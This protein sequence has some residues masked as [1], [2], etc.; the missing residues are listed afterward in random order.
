MLENLS[1]SNLAL[2][3]KSELDFSG[4]FN[5]VTGESGAGKSILM[6][7]AAILFGGKADHAAI[8]TGCAFAEVSG[9]VSVE[10]RLQ[11]KIKALL[12]EVEIPAEF[13]LLIRRRITASGVRN[14]VNDTGVG[15]KFLSLL[16]AMLIDFHAATDQLDLTIPA[17][18]LEMLDRFAGL[19]KERENCRILVGKLQELARERAD[20]EKNNVSGDEADTLREMVA[21][22]EKVNPEAGEE[23]RLAG[24]YKMIA[25]AKEVLSLC[26]RVRNALNEA[27]D[28]IVD[29]LG[30]V[31]RDLSEL[32]RLEG[33]GEETEKLLASCDELQENLNDLARKVGHLA[34][35]TDLDGEALQA[36]EARLEEL[37]A[38]KRRYKVS[39]EEELLEMT[40]SA[41]KRLSALDDADACRREFDE[42][43]KALQADL[44]KTAASLSEKRR[45]KVEK[46]ISEVKRNLAD[47]G[48]GH[49]VLRADFTPVEAGAT[50][51]DLMELVFS[52]NSGE[53]PHP[54]R[55]IAS[56]GELSRFMLA[57]KT[58]L[59]DA[60]EIPTVVFDEIDM[61]IGGETAN[62]VGEKLR[63]LGAK[64][65]IFCI[66]HLAQV[67]ARADHHFCVAKSTEKNRTVSRVAELAD[68]VPE[69]A[70]MLGGGASALRHAADL[71][72]SVRKKQK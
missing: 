54:L 41:K 13:P 18:Q 72:D 35:R 27:E 60:D 10:E 6:S 53:A 23:N 14:Y 28:S 29:R 8:R 67:A 65:Q 2:I 58:V 71:S 61:N 21:R 44:K 26:G 63:A 16:G 1:I 55:K 68:P 24:R 66:S 62:Q 69:L 32:S 34:D 37:H 50:G 43:E 19:V 11:P 42:R 30:G 47:I 3:E 39:S 70:R 15:A 46:L 36:L 64:R 25:N 56:S 20:F 51:M 9:T 17:R 5:V 57:L 49:C 45:K 31:H 59:A 48:F 12:A 38:L 33:E 4:G 40:F 7:A 22:V 52:A